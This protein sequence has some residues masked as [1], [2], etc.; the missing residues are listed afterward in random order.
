MGL[1]RLTSNSITH[2][3]LHKLNHKLDIIMF[4]IKQIFEITKSYQQQTLR[5]D[6]NTCYINHLGRRSQL[7]P[8][9]KQIC[10]TFKQLV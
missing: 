2:T 8:S 3:N 10:P 1:R 5:F 4:A 9:Q 7:P 6:H